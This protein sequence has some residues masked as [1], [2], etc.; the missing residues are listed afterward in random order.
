MAR[1]NVPIF[2]AVISNCER[3]RVNELMGFRQDWNKEII[4]QFYTIVHF[5]HIGDERAMTWMTNAQRYSITFHRFLRCFGIMVGDKDLRKLHDEVEFDKD[6][7]HL[8]YLRGDHANYGKVKNLDTYNAALNRLLRVYITPRDGNPSEITKFQKTCW[9]LLG[10]E[11]RNL[12]LGISFGKKS[13]IYPK[14][15]KRFVAIVLI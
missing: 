1:K 14:T 13:S 8:M 5:G 9:L 11:L 6:A 3:Q 15:P 2:N 4:A 12:V 7:L 10:Q